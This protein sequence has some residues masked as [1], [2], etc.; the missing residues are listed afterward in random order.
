MHEPRVG[1]LIANN[2]W[3]RCSVGG[4]AV[5]VVEHAAARK[6]VYSIISKL[7]LNDNIIDDHL[8]DR[9]SVV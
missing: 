4:E 1:K 7:S 2:D 5:D 9:K 3:R 6:D 8:L